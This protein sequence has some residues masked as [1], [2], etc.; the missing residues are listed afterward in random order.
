MNGTTVKLIFLKRKKKI[1]LKSA[2]S[3]RQFLSIQNIKQ[4]LQI[5]LKFCKRLHEFHKS[6]NTTIKLISLQHTLNASTIKH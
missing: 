1:K 6:I 3:M 2:V 5:W 4:W